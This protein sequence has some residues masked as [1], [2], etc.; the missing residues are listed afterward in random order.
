M[1][2]MHAQTRMQQ[3][4]IPPFV[5]ELL[6]RYGE[7]QYDGRGG[8]LVYFSNKSLRRMEREMGRDPVR[9]LSKY[10]RY[11]KVESSHD[12]AVIT[13]KVQYKRVKRP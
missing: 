9:L 11:A 3:R 2:S 4:G 5:D 10:H 6:D 1:V 8:V 7:R 12:G 13:M